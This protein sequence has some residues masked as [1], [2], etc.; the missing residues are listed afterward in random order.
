M[1]GN[2]KKKKT[3][4][5]VRIIEILLFMIILFIFL[6]SMSKVV[7]IT[8]EYK[9]SYEEYEKLE[10]FIEIPAELETPATADTEDKE[11]EVVTETTESTE[12]VLTETT[13][14]KVQIKYDDD[15]LDMAVDFKTL[16]SMNSDFE[17]WLYIPALDIN[18]PVVL[19][20]DN[21]FYLTHTFQKGENSAGTIFLDQA[22][23]TPFKDYNTIIHGHDMKNGSMFGK[24]DTFYRDTEIYTENPYFYIYTEEA[25]YKYLIFS[26]YVTDATSETY[27]LPTNEESYQNYKKYVTKQAVWKELDGIPDLA[28]IVTLS[29]C[30]GNNYTVKRFVV[31]GIMVNS[32]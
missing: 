9:E 5:L 15:F 2:K 6:F 7:S 12:P 4:L 20:E 28:P 31:H 8:M 25:S 29:T 23:G 32:K 21:D 1:E 10:N 30:Y 14:Q 26:Y 16:E 17:G 19:G 11:E 18:Y 24:L 3:N 27:Q 13:E 22:T